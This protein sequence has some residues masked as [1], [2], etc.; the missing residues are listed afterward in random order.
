MRSNGSEPNL[1]DSLLS[2]RPRIKIFRARDGLFYFRLY[3]YN[4]DVL[5]T[6]QGA[7]TEGQCRKNLE[8][9][10]R[11]ASRDERFK[12]HLTKDSKFTYFLL[13]SGKKVL[14]V[15]A[16]YHTVRDCDDAIRTLRHVFADSVIEG[17]S[18]PG[19]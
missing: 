9:A 19:H 6:S 12:R 16:M 14:A 7:E 4:G 8:D 5:L 1:L 11:L 17:P 15:G 2:A 13:G 10:Q 18:A 3:D